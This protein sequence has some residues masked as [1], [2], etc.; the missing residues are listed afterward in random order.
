MKLVTVSAFHETADEEAAQTFICIARSAEE[1]VDLVREYAG[2]NHPYKSIESDQE[3]TN[4]T[5]DGP[6]RVLGWCGAPAFT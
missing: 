1:A 2:A 3:V 6:A 5:L 4:A